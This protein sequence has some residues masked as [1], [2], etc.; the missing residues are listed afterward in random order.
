MARPHRSPADA[1]L[2]RV[3]EICFA[4][5][6]TAEKPSH[7][8]PA[9]FVRGKMFASFADDHHGDDRLALWCKSTKSEQE[10]RV[11]SAPERFFVPPYVGVSGWVG[12]RIDGPATDWDEVAIVVEAAWVA[13]A[14]PAAMNDAIAPPPRARPLPKTDPAVAKRA[15][16]R[17][18]KLCE[19]LPGSTSETSKRH[20]TFR[21]G[22]KPYAYFLD[23]Y[24]RDGHVAA[25]W[26]TTLED[27]AAL[28]ASDPQ[29]YYAPSYIGPR[30]WTAERLD[31]GAVD[32]SELARRITASHALVAPKRVA[33]P[34]AR[35]KR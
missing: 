11:A 29:R 32:W 22:K 26:K 34:A 8:A 6:G 28:I 17:L 10:R 14:P 35:S 18:E 20:A 31:R 2:E 27:Q 24:E 12:V 30:G 13:A 21:V 3:R 9:F 16:E 19:G 4:F 1:A 23:N 25:T 5:P 33:K 7:G 15:L